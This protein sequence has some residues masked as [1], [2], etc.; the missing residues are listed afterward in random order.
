MCNLC[1]VS[2]RSICTLRMRAP[3]GADISSATNAVC[4]HITYVGVESAE[5]V[6]TLALV[7]NYTTHRKSRMIWWIT[8][9]R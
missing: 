2:G 9:H 8:A 7:Y 4:A 1:A 6:S 3:I 5:T